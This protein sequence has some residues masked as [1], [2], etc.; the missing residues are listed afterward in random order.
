VARRVLCVGGMTR[1]VLVATVVAALAGTAAADTYVGLGLGTTPSVDDKFVA[2]TTATPSGRSAR[3]LVGMRFGNVSVEGAANGFGVVLP[4]S[5]DQTVYQG[6]LAAKLS[7]PLGSNFEG[8][9][10]GG[11]E[12]TWLTIGDQRYDYTGDGYLL[13]GG[14]EFRLNAI[15]A[16]ASLFVDYNFHK[17]T[18]TNTTQRFEATSGM[19]GLGLTVGL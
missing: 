2:A 8:F 19:W 11:V 14:F 7:I 17:T 9:A 5:G 15:L 18:L 16:N 6:S 13:G 3:G 4:T 1:T 10:R 12:R